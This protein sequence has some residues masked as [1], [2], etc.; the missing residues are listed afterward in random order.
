MKLW[1]YAVKVADLDEASEFYV[2]ALNGEPRIA[3]TVLGCDYRLLRLG[4]TRIILFTRAPYEGL[5]DEEVPLGFLHAV[6]EVEDFDARVAA[7]KRQ[8]AT[9]IMQPQEI[10]AEFGRRRIAFFVTPG[11]VRTEIMEIIEDSGLA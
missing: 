5:L 3:G 11:G 1:N 9:F 2:K 10:T 4:D 6:F 8:G 7:L